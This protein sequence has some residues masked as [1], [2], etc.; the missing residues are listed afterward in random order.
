MWGQHGSG[1]ACNQVRGRHVLVNNAEKADWDVLRIIERCRMSDVEV[2]FSQQVSREQLFHVNFPRTSNERPVLMVLG[3]SKWFCLW[4]SNSW[5]AARIW[6]SRCQA[7]RIYTEMSAAASVHG[8]PDQLKVIEKKLRESPCCNYTI[9]WFFG[10]FGF[11]FFQ[12][13]LCFVHPKS[14][15]IVDNVE[16][17][18]SKWSKMI[19]NDWWML[20]FFWFQILRQMTA[21]PTPTEWLHRLY[22]QSFRGNGVEVVVCDLILEGK[23]TCS[24]EL[25]SYD[26]HCKLEWAQNDLHI[27]DICCLFSLVAFPSWGVLLWTWPISP[28]FVAPWPASEVTGTADRQGFLR[29]A[30]S[31]RFA[32]LA[33][34]RSECLSA[35]SAASNALHRGERW[36]SWSH[37]T[38]TEIG[39]KMIVVKCHVFV[40]MFNDILCYF[41]CISRT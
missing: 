40:D 12:D 29:N 9:C 28:F 11:R 3:W 13:G 27:C 32:A 18:N 7:K 5:K 21:C 41:Q 30:S 4:H 17:W 1:K 31:T 19:Q 25:W 20:S 6:P 33:M 24:T 34:E 36:W 38:H 39:W 26:P 14:I 10:C 22:S 23:T 35:G 8:Q 37:D 16:F 2:Q 15:E